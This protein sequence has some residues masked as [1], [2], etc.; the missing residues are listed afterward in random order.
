MVKSITAFVLL[1]LMTGN[2]LAGVPAHSGEHKCAVTELTDCCA[3]AQSRGGTPAVSA[4]QLCCIS[5]C[6]EPGTAAPSGGIN[7]RPV[8]TVALQSSTVRPPAAV[9]ALSSLRFYVASLPQ[10]HSQPA[11]IRHLA[12]LI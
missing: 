1:V 7:L 6:T 10:Q 4:A 9:T 12:L 8:S 2:M 11:Y 3:I 5:N